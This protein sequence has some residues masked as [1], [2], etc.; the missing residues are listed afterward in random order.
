[1]SLREERSR[2]I[3]CF[4]N[5]RLVNIESGNL[6]KNQWRSGTLAWM[7]LLEG[8]SDAMALNFVKRT[9]KVWSFFFV[10]EL[11]HMQE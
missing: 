4:S 3:I 8:S 9:T 1:M 10:L 6:M 7:S 5:S 2:I 11:E